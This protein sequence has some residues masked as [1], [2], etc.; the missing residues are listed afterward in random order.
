MS[1]PGDLPDPEMEPGS[2]V[3]PVSPAF[4]TTVPPGKPSLSYEMSLYADMRVRTVQA[5][6]VTHFLIKKDIYIFFVYILMVVTPM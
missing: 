4:F 3:S 5:D 2:P 6:S 1:A